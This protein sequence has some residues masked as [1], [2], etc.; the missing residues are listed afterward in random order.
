ML[1][2]MY[3]LTNLHVVSWG[4]REV[5]PTPTEEADAVQKELDVKAKQAGE[6]GKNKVMAMLQ[7][8]A[9]RGFCLYWLGLG[10]EG[11]QGA[12][13]HC[14]VSR[15]MHVNNQNQCTVFREYNSLFIYF[16]IVLRGDDPFKLFDGQ[17]LD[18]DCTD[19]SLSWPEGGQRLDGQRGIVV[20]VHLLPQT[21]PLGR[22]GQVRS[23]P[24]QT[25][26]DGG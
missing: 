1:L 5:K 10:T 22:V 2:M 15:S 6:D 7:K 14:C 12:W 16:A 19:L 26:R 3:S 21:S 24:H 18:T 23:H 20:P 13:I 9:G 25:G 8:V 4:T 17:R 11:R